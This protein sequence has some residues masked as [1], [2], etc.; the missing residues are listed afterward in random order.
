[1]TQY[2]LPRQNKTW[3][4]HCCS[5][6]WNLRVC[7]MFGARKNGGFW[8]RN[9]GRNTQEL[10]PWEPSQCWVKSS[11]ILLETCFWDC[12]RNGD[13]LNWDVHR[14]VFNKTSSDVHSEELG[15]VLTRLEFY[16]TDMGLT[17][18]EHQSKITGHPSIRWTISDRRCLIIV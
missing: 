7:W 17:T 11:S 8:N 2:G 1:M 5:C 12:D 3:I 4:K 13:L 9:L 10:W 16:S 18:S 14:D 15:F 6:C